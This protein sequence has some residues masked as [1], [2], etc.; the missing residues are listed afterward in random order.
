MLK[1]QKTLSLL[2]HLGCILSPQSA[3]F[4]PLVCG[5]KFKKLANMAF[6][7]YPAEY[8]PKTHGIYD[9][10]RFYGKREYRFELNLRL[11][12]IIFGCRR[13]CNK[14]FNSIDSPKLTT[15]PANDATTPV[16]MLS[17]SF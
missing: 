16:L 1:I 14:F 6:G 9:P 3:N 13:L 15:I 8:N 4:V 12:G 2:D 10:A 7:D 11:L 17:L 5:R